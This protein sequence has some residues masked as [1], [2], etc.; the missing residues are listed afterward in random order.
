REGYSDSL[1]VIGGEIRA[2]GNRPDGSPW[3]IGVETPRGQKRTIER[4]VQ[5]QNAAIGTSGAWEN[6]FTYN[7]VRYSHVI[8]PQTARPVHHQVAGVTVIADRAIETDAW[9][10]ALLVIGDQRGIPWCEENKVAAIFF[11]IT[12]G[13]EIEARESSHVAERIIP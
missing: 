4:K 13:G 11:V 5:I 6:S 9:A 2:S 3:R 12:P 10:T 7:W 1:V 8:D